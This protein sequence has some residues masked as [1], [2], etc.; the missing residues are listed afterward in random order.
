MARHRHRLVSL[1]W[2]P[3][4][5]ESDLET[6]IA[7]LDEEEFI[8]GQVG[9]Q[10]VIVRLS[11]DERIDRLMADVQA[12]QDSLTNLQTSV[13]DL[14]TRVT[15]DLQGLHDQID[16]LNAQIQAGGQPD[17]QPLKDQVDAIISQVGSIDIPPAP[18]ADQPPPS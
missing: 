4:P 16:A 12:L 7:S 14:Q 15:N 17:L 9:H 10:V 2:I 5:G 6:I 1:P 11:P 3:T 8:G 18:P 13:N